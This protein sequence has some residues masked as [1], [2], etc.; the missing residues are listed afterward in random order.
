MAMMQSLLQQ[1]QVFFLEHQEAQREMMA[2]LLDRQREEMAAYKKELKEHTRKR[3]E[4]V[5]KLKPPKPTLQKL[6]LEDDIENF[7]SAFERIATQQGW[8]KDLWGPQLAGL[9]IGK[10]RAA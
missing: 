9:L 3:E 10:A 8:T 5:A 2:E 7:T 4:H 1:Q 6:V